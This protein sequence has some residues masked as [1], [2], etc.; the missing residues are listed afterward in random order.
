[1]RAS[2]LLLVISVSIMSSCSNNDTAAKSN[3]A[4]SGKKTM[5]QWIDSARN[6]GKINQGQ[7]LA[8]SFKFKNA[9]NNPLIIESVRPGCGC[10][11][12]D[13]P[14]E[15]IAPGAESEITGSF[16]SHGREGLQH[17]EITVKANTPGNGEQQIFFD[18]DVVKNSGSSNTNN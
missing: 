7:K 12:A 5:I 10:T 4:P 17:K 15:A 16:D 2:L 9:G 3:A 13:F 1:M 8:V 18:V 6:Y 14:R 11:V